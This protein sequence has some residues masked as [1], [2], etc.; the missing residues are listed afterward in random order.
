LKNGLRVVEDRVD[1][2]AG[3]PRELD[4]VQKADK[5][6]MPVALHAAADHGALEHAERGE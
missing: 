6:L 5:L 1:H 2:L 4:G 3:R